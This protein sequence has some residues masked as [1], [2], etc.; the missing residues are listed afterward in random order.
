M[1][2]PIDR[3]VAAIPASFF[4]AA[5][6]QTDAAF[7]KAARLTDQNIAEPERANTL[8]QLRHACAEEGFRAAAQEAGLAPMVPHTEPAGGRFSLVDSQGV[9]LIRSN[10]QTHCGTP[11]PTRFRKLWAAV[12]VWLDP[13]QLDFLIEVENPPTDRLCA[14]LVVTASGKRDDPSLPA[15]V[16]LGIPS[17]DL[18]CWKF[19]EPLTTVLGMYHDLETRERTPREAPLE[20]KDRAVPK[21]KKRGGNK[22]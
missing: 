17:A 2:N 20:I 14:M 21:L 10:I 15:F 3:V 11:R 18:S 22:D 13:L 1:L 19:L 7:M 4:Q 6:E 5:M 8:G 16:G 9:Y 12:N